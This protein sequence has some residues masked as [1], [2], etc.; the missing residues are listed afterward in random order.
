MTSADYVAI[1]ISPALVMALVG[2]L[3][4]FL[5]EVLYVG[6]YQARLTYAFG[7]FVFAAVLITRIAIELGSERAALFALAL[8]VAMFLVL[9]RFVEHESPFS[10]I[11]NIALMAIVW[12]CSHK[13]TWDCTLI[14]DS[15]DASGE[16]LMQRVGIDGTDA[17]DEDQ[18]SA[19]SKTNE[20]F[21]DADRDASAARPWW[22]RLFSTKRGPHTPGL[23]V[24][25]FSL[26]ALPIF[27]FGQHWI[28]V[29]D[30]GR[31]RY[32]FALLLVY[33]LAGLGLLV[34]TSFLGLRRYLRQRRV[35]MPNPM[36]ATW[37][38][39]GAALILVIMF[40][41]MLIPRPAAEYAISQGPWQV[42][43]PGDLSASRTSM[44]NDGADEEGDAGAIS[45]EAKGD[46]TAPTEKGGELARPSDDA[47][48]PA[49]P[50]GNGEQGEQGESGNTEQ[51]RPQD[52]AAGG[53][54]G[55]H[56]AEAGGEPADGGREQM[57]ESQNVT[58]TDDERTDAMQD[59]GQSAAEE[60]SRRQ[61]TAD[62]AQPSGQTT[63]EQLPQQ[64]APSHPTRIPQFITSIFGNLGA[65]LKMLFYA[66][67]AVVVGYL[68]W[69]YRRELLGALA[70]ILRDLRGLLAR[71]FGGERAATDTTHSDKV[72][73][74]VRARRF[75][76]FQDPFA[77]GAYRQLAPEEIVRHTFAAFEAW[78]NDHGCPRTPDRTPY[79]LV[80][81]A[82]SPQD[83]IFAEAR[84]MVQMYGE[85]AYAGRTI[86]REAAAELRTLWAM[87]RE[88]RTATPA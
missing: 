86:T 18:S 68:F 27:G 55:E 71:L 75:A 30:T 36:A 82:I 19:G 51:H 26:A 33:V 79:E 87:M 88:A 61:P 77:T 31:R 35:E 53:E 66:L 62:S 78:A 47:G 69:K 15:E 70:D 24:L 17:I 40:V 6:D 34:T 21:G 57:G 2:S 54:A 10:A 59:D 64:A 14:D 22:Q 63:I 49:R 43:S 5:I 42:K 84:R 39:T 58:S 32:A 46:S 44:G 4:F 12:W 67:L 38:A 65:V 16:G 83:P 80:R 11:I 56:A 25:Y 1:A 74:A 81:E 52:S 8:G 45:D 50:Q 7:L 48:Q 41:A 13:L 28:A 9:A 29:G 85:L 72:V 37:V 76:D 20:L 23:W 60:E 3:V 73:P